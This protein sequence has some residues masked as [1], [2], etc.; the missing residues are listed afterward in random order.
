MARTVL[1]VD[2]DPKIVALVRAS[3]AIPA[4][5]SAPRTT[6]R[7]ARAPSPPPGP[8]RARPALSCP[9]P[10]A[11]AAR[12]PCRRP[13]RRRAGAQRR[14]LR[15]PAARPPG[16]RRRPA[17]L[18]RDRP[19]GRLP[20]GGRAGVRRLVD[21]LAARIALAALAVSAL[22]VGIVAVG[23]L[24]VGGAEF[25]QLMLE[26]GSSDDA[27]RSMFQQSVTNVLLAAVAV[28]VLS[29]V[30][31]GLLLARAISRPLD[32]IGAAPRPLA[33]GGPR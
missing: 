19:R 9:A 7:R 30:G 18:H 33:P 4:T 26:H 22:A 31:G 8:P 16:R 10:A 32:P 25:Q 12:R 2:D 13:R 21:G 29:A 14:R 27:A 24:L 15:G 20:A 23:V 17:R 6:A 3:L 11:W 1:V 28:A 5:T